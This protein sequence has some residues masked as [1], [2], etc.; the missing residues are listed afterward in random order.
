MT[1]IFTF[2]V[3]GF[4]ATFAFVAWTLPAPQAQATPQPAPTPQVAAAYARSAPPRR[5]AKPGVL[6]TAEQPPALEHS[7]YEHSDYRDVMLR[8]YMAGDFAVEAPVV[9]TVESDPASRREARLRA[10]RWP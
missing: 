5:S 9:V 3:V 7:D 10:R 6:H 1:R 2:A 8:R 4:A